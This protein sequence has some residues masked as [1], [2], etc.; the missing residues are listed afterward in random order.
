[1]DDYFQGQT[2]QILNNMIAALAADS[3]RTFIWAEI[4]YFSMWWDTIT[5]ETKS[6]VKRY[7]PSTVLFFTA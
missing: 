6:L 1:M 3:S 5:D 4:S 2:K 7:Q